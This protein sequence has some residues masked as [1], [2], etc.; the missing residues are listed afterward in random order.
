MTEWQ[1][2]QNSHG[3]FCTVTTDLLG[4]PD[5]SLSLWPLVAG[6]FGSGLNKRGCVQRPPGQ[7]FRS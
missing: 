4:E 5:L 3:L 1:E 6:I 7:V 2:S